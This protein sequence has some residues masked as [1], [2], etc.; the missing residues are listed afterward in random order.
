MRWPWRLTGTG[1]LLVVAWA[2]QTLSYVLARARGDGVHEILKLGVERQGNDSMDDFVRRLQALGLKGREAYV[3]LRPEQYQLLQIDAPA[4]PPEE[5]RAAARYQIREMIDSH[6]DD[7]TLDVMRVGDGQ[8]KG[9]GNL[10]VVAANNAVVR[11]ALEL[12][13]AMHWTVSVIDIQ[14]TAQR[15]LQSAVAAREGRASRASAALVLVPG[16]QAVLTISANEEL[17]YT[18]RLE[19]S[20]QFLAESW[21]QAASVPE[22]PLDAFTPVEEYVPEHSAGGDAYG[23]DYA[24]PRSNASSAQ[25]G[26]A[27]E[28]E[29]A[30]R[31]LVE[32]QR[33]L[34]VWDRTW[35]SLPLGGVSVFAGQRTRELAK[36]LGEQLGQSVAPLDMGALFPGFDAAAEVDQSMCLPLLGVLMRTVERKL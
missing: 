17:F 35:S 34:D 14:E 15:N 32:V 20:E 3:M 24:N 2:A 31:F 19:V 1:D 33:S 18:R 25:S 9:A 27:G 28:S 23:N 30:Q 36:W 16:H 21:G 12:C 26:N 13:N 8:Q 6:V 22:S 7:V 5:L 11:S 29:G 4:V 10:F